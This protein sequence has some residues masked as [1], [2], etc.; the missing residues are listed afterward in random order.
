MFNLRKPPQL[1]S[2]D[3]IAIVAPSLPLLPSWE[4][5]IERGKQ[6]LQSLGFQVAEGELVRQRRW[7]SAGTPE[8]LAGEINRLFGSISS[9]MRLSIPRLKRRF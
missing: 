7:W 8:A 6:V 5:Q 2:G 3:T 4:G 1:Q 9:L